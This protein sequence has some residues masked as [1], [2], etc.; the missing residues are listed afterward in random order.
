MFLGRSCSRCL[1]NI[2]PVAQWYVCEAHVI[3]YNVDDL[4]CVPSNIQQ[5]S[6]MLLVVNFYFH[7]Q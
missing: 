7:F 3:V 6:L 5:V 1:F 2:K 4:P